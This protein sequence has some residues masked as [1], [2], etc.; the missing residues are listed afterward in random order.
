MKFYITIAVTGGRGYNDKATIYRVLDILNA[1]RR[2][3]K[4]IEGGATGV[5]RLCRQWAIDRGI[6]YETVEAE[7]SKHGKAAGP[8]RNGWMLDR[9]PDLVV[10]FPGGRGTANMKNQTRARNIPLQDISQEI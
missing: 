8:L 10:A 5:D 7:W 4:L 2:I 1:A 9:N 6:S 3:S